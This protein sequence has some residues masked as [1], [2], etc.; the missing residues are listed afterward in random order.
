[1]AF[2]TLSWVLVMFVTVEVSDPPPDATLIFIV[3]LVGIK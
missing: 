1:M 2:V 3:E